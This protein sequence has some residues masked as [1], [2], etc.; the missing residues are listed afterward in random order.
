MIPS[1]LSGHSPLSVCLGQRDSGKDDT[2]SFPSLKTSESFPGII[3]A[4][5]PLRWRVGILQMKNLRHSNSSKVVCGVNSGQDVILVRVHLFASLFGE[6]MCSVGC[7]VKIRKVN[8]RF[9]SL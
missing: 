8:L 2:A 5:N 4:V 3:K 6:Q 7:I 9:H 1:P